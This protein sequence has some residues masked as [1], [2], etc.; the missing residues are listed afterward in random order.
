MTDPRAPLAARADRARDHLDRIRHVYRRGLAEVHGAGGIRYDGGRSSGPHSA[1]PPGTD[2]D[3]RAR[4]IRTVR[5]IHDAHQE[6][7]GTV[8]KP[9]TYH[10]IGSR[11]GDLGDVDTWESDGLVTFR[12]RRHWNPEDAS[13]VLDPPHPDVMASA[14][15]LLA[16]RLQDLRAGDEQRFHACRSVDK[17]VGTLRS[18]GLWDVPK[19]ARHVDDRCV[20]FP[21]CTGF[22]APDRTECSACSKHRYRRRRRERSTMKHSAVVEG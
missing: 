4:L 11:S 17:A 18:A 21:S 22:R 2:V 6:L 8:A 20:H 9:W 16:S 14:C 15:G 13:D 5:H 1:R 3:L 12:L 19:D 7:T 10:R